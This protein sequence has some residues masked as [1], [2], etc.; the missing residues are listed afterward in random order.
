MTD[1]YTRILA[2]VFSSAFIWGVMCPVL[3]T[4][5]FKIFIFGGLL[6]VFLPVVIGYYLFKTPINNYNSNKNKYEKT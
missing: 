2:F 6:S 5:T 4:S 1:I 3:L